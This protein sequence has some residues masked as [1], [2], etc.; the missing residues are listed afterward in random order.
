MIE[1]FALGDRR[2]IV[3]L[4]SLARDNNDQ[5]GINKTIPIIISIQPHARCC[6]LSHSLSPSSIPSKA[7]CISSP[8]LSNLTC[9]PLIALNLSSIAFLVIPDISFNWSGV[10]EGGR[11]GF[12]RGVEVVEIVERGR[13]GGRR[14][15]KVGLVVAVE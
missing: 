10:G 11:K 7:P 12:D 9:Q 6:S 1:L 13:K 4:T 5:K 8:I 15:V 2:F 3:T 14:G